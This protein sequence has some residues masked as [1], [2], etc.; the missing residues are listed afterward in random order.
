MTAP[1]GGFSEIAFSEPTREMHGF[2][3]QVMQRRCFI[4]FSSISFFIVGAGIVMPAWVAFDVGGSNLVGLVL[5]AS[6]VAG[7]ALAPLSGHLVDRHNHLRVTASDNSSELWACSCWL[8]YK[9]CPMRSRVLSS[10]YQQFSELSAT[11]F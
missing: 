6:S 11:R 8:R 10:F 3:S 9:F 1:T 7:F 5:L 2:H 4:G